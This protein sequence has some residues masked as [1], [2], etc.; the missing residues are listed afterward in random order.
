MEDDDIVKEMPN[1]WWMTHSSCLQLL[2]VLV[3]HG[4]PDIARNPTVIMDVNTGKTTRE[5]DVVEMIKHCHHNQLCGAGVG[6]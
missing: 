5:K 2:A 1:D 3:H 4:N 6:K